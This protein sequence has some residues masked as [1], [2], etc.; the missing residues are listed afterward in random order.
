MKTIFDKYNQP[1]QPKVYLGTINNN[2]ICILNGIDEE[3]FSI[4][5]NTNNTFELSFDVHRF[6]NIEGK[7]VET[8]G[9]NLID[10][11]MRIYVD[12][13]GWFCIDPP[14]ITNDGIKE[15]KTIKGE[16]AEI[17]M[18]NHNINGLKINKGTTDSYE[19]LVDG[20]VDVI[21]DGVEFAKEQIRFC[22]KNKEDLS[23]LHILLKVS[24]M[25]G[26][27]IGYIDDVPKMRKSYVDGEL[28]ETWTLLS[29]E[30]G[31][32]DIDTQDLYSFLT[33]DAAKFFECVFVFDFLHFTINAYRP[34]N[35]GRDTN[36]NIGFRNL[37]NSNSIS[38]DE[39]NIFTRYA[40]YGADGLD[41]KYVN[42]GSNIIENLDY[43]L[44]EKYMTP[45]L[46]YKY[47][48]WKNDVET[49]RIDYIEKTRQYNEQQKVISELYDRVPLDDCSTD[50]S[51]FEDE[52]LLEAQANYQAQLKGY[53]QFY[54]DE[55]GNFDEE[56]LKASSDAN[57]YY[58]IR[59][60]ILP[61]IQIEID[62]R[63]ISDPDSDDI[64][65][66]IDSYLT[67][68]KLYGL[69]ELQVKLD[70][71]RNTK[72][73]CEDQGY[74]I[75]Y[76]ED[77]G[78]SEDIHNKMYEKYLEAINQLN[79]DFIG[80]CQEAYNKRKQ[81]I[82]DATSLS[83]QY[84][85]ER[86]ELA[87]AYDKQ[88][89]NN[90]GYSFT[91]ADLKILSH[92]YI[93]NTYT[94]DNMFLT[95]S[96]DAVSAIDE[97]LKLLNASKEDLEIAS[98]PQYIYSTNLDNF[99]A[100][101]DY[102]NY[103][104]NFNVG[105]FIYLGVRDDYSVKLRVISIVSNPL[106]MDNNLQITF[107][108]MLRSRSK[109]DDWTYLLGGANSRG[110]SS[111]TGNSNGYLTNE[112]IGL[113]AGLIQKLLSSGAF[114]NKVSQIINNEFGLI[115]GSGG[116]GGSGSGSIS[117]EELNAK[118]IKVLDLVVQNGFF[119]YLQAKLISVDTIVGGS[120]K[121]D[122]LSALVAKIDNLLAGNISVDLGHII[123]LTADNVTINEAVIKDIIAA[124]MTVGMLSAS[125]I[126]TEKFHIT[127]ADGGLEIV[128]NTMQFKDAN[129]TVRIQIGRDANNNFTF[130]LYDAEGKGI[131]LDENGIHESAI[132]D[133]LIKNDMVGD[134]E[135][136]KEKFN[137]D[138]IE[139]DGNG[140]LDAKR[141]LIN[142]KGIDAEFLSIR[143]EIITIKPYTLRIF[144]SNGR[145]FSVGKK[146]T[147]L[148]P[149]LYWGDEDVTE[150]YDESCFVWTRQ[151]A[152]SDGDKYWN[153]A[154][155][156]GT[157]SMHITTADVIK[158]AD[159]TCS[160]TYEGQ[161]LATTT[162]Y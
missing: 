12:N 88:Q 51:T 2:P 60:V 20:N 74:D 125:D 87:K 64:L 70:S 162:F 136:G 161:V 153:L 40:V 32:F 72:K 15:F 113:T 99:L 96:D 3:T 19:M 108:N 5:Q 33:Q 9:Y 139:G 39:N 4:T 46:I 106:K 107:S 35:L 89:W 145:V 114:S 124:Q 22:N 78:H 13:F 132:A 98:Q 101:Y 50:W 135:L 68:W 140:N 93:D 126:S 63:E 122:E 147:F 142:G 83:D 115:I 120:A 28:V 138:V 103:I 112:G 151:S 66:Y 69:D 29:D 110:K 137:F 73:I 67:D 42:F 160:F 24:D 75:P 48:M 65:D 61:S 54:V 53:E 123:N 148:S 128:G 130:C 25:Y 144:S 146:D 77:S 104:D 59:D 30:I 90:N 119:E 79:P 143:N 23:F 80:G 26:W 71:Y 91:K 52:E 92:L 149:V 6:I 156:T 21:E 159:F 84:N 134:G 133:G 129:N 81:E 157:K 11:L 31:T 95:N 86:K 45:T 27:S 116:S 150:K 105:D 58:Q 100:N 117:I 158:S 141:V 7:E 102:K 111:S 47:K 121:F 16:S 118:M 56:A 97:Q 76:D 82:D 41:I 131:L 49:K 17:E 14:T 155:Q 94:N 1:V 127:S 44:N 62:N 37:Q 152:D 18:A 8:N 36:I 154:H 34:E 55:D 38:V 43:F 57:D 109:R 10:V 85:T